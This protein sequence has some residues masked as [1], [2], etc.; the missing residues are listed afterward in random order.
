MLQNQQ[1]KLAHKP[2]PGKKQPMMESHAVMM[3]KNEKI[4]SASQSVLCALQHAV[5]QPALI[6][7][8]QRTLVG[9]LLPDPYVRSSQIPVSVVMMEF[10]E[11]PSSPSETT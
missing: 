1:P 3:P 11:K 9:L 2:S 8:S 6:G 4:F 5:V 10:L 7:A